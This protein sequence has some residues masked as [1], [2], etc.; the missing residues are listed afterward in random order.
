MKL[1]DLIERKY[2]YFNNTY[3]IVLLQRPEPME[4]R[5]L[6]NRNPKLTGVNFCPVT[7]KSNDDTTVW[8]EPLK[9]NHFVTEYNNRFTFVFSVCS[10][11]ENQIKI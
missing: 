5:S 8:N 3:F 7:L 2:N 6:E 11:E 9:E 10:F 1:I 4:Y